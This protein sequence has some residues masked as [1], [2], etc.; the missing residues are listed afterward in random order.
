M[1]ERLSFQDQIQRNKIKSFLLIV[2]MFGIFVLIGYLISLSVDPSYFFVIMIFATIFSLSYVLISYYNSDKI[3]IASVGAKKASR[4]TQRKF[5]HA[6]ESMSIASGLPM[7]KLF[8]MKSEQINAFA[9]G[10]DPQHAVICV[11]TGALEKLDKQELEGVIAHEMSHIANYDMRFMTTVAVVVGLISIV[12]QIFLRS[13]WFSSGRDRK[14]NGW[15]LVVTIVAAI[16]APLIAQLVSLAI[17][18][19]REFSADAT[20]VK[21]TR[22]PKGLKSALEK[23]KNEHP[24]EEEK[25]KYSQAIAPLFISDPFKKKVSGLFATHPSL[26]IRINKLERM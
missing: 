11:T 24:G 17:S 21:F 16:L 15:I 22:Y 8:V 14:G 1:T 6:V 3:A 26:E 10:R 7:P 5:Y 4:E 12:A 20:A 13:L 25:K 23:I 19:K 18:R 2:F 9:T